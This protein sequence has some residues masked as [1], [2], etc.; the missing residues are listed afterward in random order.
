[1]N[2]PD[3]SPATVR[4]PFA[5]CDVDSR[6]EIPANPPGFRCLDFIG[7]VKEW[8]VYVVPDTITRDSFMRGHPEL[9]D[10]LLLPIYENRGL[11]IQQDA[12]YALPGF[13]VISFHAQYRSLDEIDVRQAMRSCF[14][15][16]ELRRA[17][18]EQL[19]I[20]YVHMHYEEKASASFNVHYSVVPAPDD[21]FGQPLRLMRTNLREYLAGYR[22]SEQ[23]AVID[24][25]NRR[26]VSHFEATGL[27]GR[28]DALANAIAECRAA[29]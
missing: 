25:Y 22:M 4:V 14:I 18:R 27:R 2:F 24:A 28:D 13:Y 1:M 20:Q 3:F 16:R 26:L 7:G 10:P 6:K 29:L 23:R 8:R 12:S 11:T 21:G 9:F 17:M 5:H 19:G 15:T